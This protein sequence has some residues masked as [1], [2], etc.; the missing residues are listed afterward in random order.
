MTRNGKQIGV[1]QSYL[2]VFDVPESDLMEQQDFKTVGSCKWI[3]DRA[4]FQKWR[5]PEEM[6]SVERLVDGSTQPG[7][8]QGLQAKVE[9]CHLYW[10]SA[11]PGTGKT[12]CA[13]HVIG[14]LQSRGL[15]CSYFFF[16]FGNRAKQ[17]LSSLF[18]SL[19][20]HM[21]I[22]H[23]SIRQSLQLMQSHGNTF[24]K[25]DEGGI[26]RKVF[27]NVIFRTRLDRPQ[28]WVIDSLDECLLNE[29]LFTFL[30]SLDVDFDL[31]IFVTSRPTP[32]IDRSFSR[33]A[34][35]VTVDRITRADTDTDMRLYL[36]TEQENLPVYTAE[37]RASLMNTML[38]KSA[39]CFLWMRLVQQ[40]LQD[41]YSED[42]IADVLEEI[43]A[44]MS[45]LYKRSIEGMSKKVREARLI[46]ALLTWT[47]CSI[48]PL[49]LDELQIALKYDD[50][51]QVRELRKSIE[52][53]C[54]NLLYVD[55]SARVQL[56]HSTA[57]DFLLD[58]NLDSDLAIR[59]EAGHERLALTCLKFIHDEMRPP[60]SRSLGS[61]TGLKKQERP[62]LADYA[63]TAF[64]EHVSASSSTSDALL[65]ALTRF[66]QMNVLAW[67][68]YVASEKRNL[69]I[70]MRTAK[71]FKKYLE[72]R[73]KYVSPLGPEV[74]TIES[75]STDLI[76]LV[77]KFGKN[78]IN[79]P[80][81]IFFLIPSI[82]PSESKLHQQ[83]LSGP[84]WLEVNGGVAS[85]W[86]DCVAIIDYKESW[87][88]AIACGDNVF[89]IGLK[90][91]L[92]TIYDQS[93]CQERGSVLHRVTDESKNKNAAATSNRP[94]PVKLLAFDTSSQRLASA[95]PQSI[96]V[97]SLAGD[98]LQRFSIKEPCV[99]I[100]FALGHD[101]LITVSRASRVLF[102]SLDE[103][104]EDPLFPTVR[105]LSSGSVNP[106][107][108]VVPR[109]AP[110]AAAI[111]P[112][113]TMLALL[114]RGRPVYLWSLQDNTLLGLCGRDLAMKTSNISVLTA[115]FNPNVE[116]GLLVIAYQD[117]E[118]ALYD[119]WAQTELMSVDG[120]AY[121][122]AATPD[123]RTLGTG[124]TRGTIQIW[125][126]ETL[127]LLYRIRSGLDEV[128]HLA[129]SGDG[130]RLVDIR[131]SK[132]KIWEPSAL[133]RRTVEEDASVSDA[134]TPEAQTVGKNEDEVEITAAISA[135][136]GQLVFAGRS[137]GSIV[138][139]DA[140]S[141]Q[142][143]TTLYKH[144]A[145]L[146]ITAIDYRSGI[147]ASADVGGTILVRT[148]SITPGRGAS[149]SPLLEQQLSEPVQ[150]LLVDQAG[151]QI[152]V[153]T[154]S[155]DSAWSLASHVGSP[156]HRWSFEKTGMHRR[157][158]QVAD[159]NLAIYCED[160]VRLYDRMSYGICG[161]YLL[162]RHQ[163][164]GSETEFSIIRALTT[165]EAQKHVIAAFCRSVDDNS[166]AH[167]VTWIAPFTP[168]EAQLPT[169][170]TK[171]ILD[172]SSKQVKTFLGV[173]GSS[174][175]FLDQ[176]LWVC[177]VDL[178]E[179]Q[180]NVSSAIR[181][182][183]FVSPD[184]IGSQRNANALLTRAGDVVFAKYAELAIIKGG[185]DWSYG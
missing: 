27:V 130:S 87:A 37:Q 155:G 57:R 167:L 145:D 179:I 152:I 50:G 83:S 33:L 101:A 181:R 71:N 28:Y 89:A 11:K 59:R 115:L 46:K 75:W 169:V 109:Q 68:E 84:R 43:P 49:T 165:D 149:A 51:L 23:P 97:W 177:S 77:T 39:G 7:P 147:I 136:D 16:K 118:L 38:L 113:Q 119:A 63:S 138:A 160:Q 70:L 4:G 52:G 14:H 25:D 151:S 44:E 166:A 73:A 55:S 12:V 30:K 131:D 9:R 114:Y 48:R 110:L 182:H 5:D 72:R 13:A 60:R 112:D 96:C 185:L 64:S 95:S 93:T 31:R 106:S 159:G 40:E 69:Y 8:N 88:T 146:V 58:K 175:V 127:T 116:S 3:E 183:F 150:Q 94:A 164:L 67:I 142:L 104:D 156:V 140:R 82:A 81:S 6:L 20:Y 36:N 102:W 45:D 35:P 103:T 176:E 143:L 157:W 168:A 108:N 174:I 180:V 62:L 61:R 42:S 124:D 98:L 22:F 85:S 120:N 172:L 141:G 79:Y 91:G 19:A 135:E 10:L 132:T 99:T 80:S 100:A 2:N 134:L 158:M 111:S 117:G 154:G 128:R 32:E 26:W 178:D 65:V 123:G 86:D 162:P 90:N 54:G 56:I 107:V 29:K 1:L 18:R 53:L 41:T 17:T 122:L 173:N 47:V 153:S 78:L 184:W 76:R 24:D 34:L 161:C 74:A 21:S 105:R 126:F 125:D 139:H 121:T 15:D 137:D 148:V 129:F 144:G 163:S 171:P 92:I 66:L 170:Q 133:I